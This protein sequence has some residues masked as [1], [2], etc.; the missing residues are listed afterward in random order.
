MAQAN[1]V[2][3]DTSIAFKLLVPE[4][5]S[6][7]ADEIWSTWMAYGVRIAVPAV[8]V[9]ELSN[10]MH[11][12]IAEGETTLERG[13]AGLLEMLEMDLEVHDMTPLT[14]RALQLANLIEQ[15]AVYDSFYLAL[16]ERLDCD[17]WT[18]DN[19]FHRAASAHSDRVRT[20]TQYTL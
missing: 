9:A 13:I 17:L 2:V 5:D 8:F 19:R 16:A 7:I 12:S 6:H 11:R 3:V 1:V 14:R 4:P 10:A 20:L 18:A 15:G